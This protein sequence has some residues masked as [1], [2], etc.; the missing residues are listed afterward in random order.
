MSIKT[1]ALQIRGERTV[2]RD[3]GRDRGRPSSAAGPSHKA[4]PGGRAAPEKAAADLKNFWVNGINGRTDAVNGGVNGR[5]PS[6][7]S[8]TASGLV[9]EWGQVSVSRRTQTFSG[10]RSWPACRTAGCLDCRETGGTY[11]GR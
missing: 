3:A 5:R 9:R 1:L 6:A 8:K 11:V 10:A 2:A 7:R 4:C